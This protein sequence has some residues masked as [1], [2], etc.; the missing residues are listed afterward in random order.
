M[1][2]LHSKFVLYSLTSTTLAGFATQRAEDYQ[3]PQNSHNECLIIQS[4][5][6]A[7]CHDRDDFEILSI[8]NHEGCQDCFWFLIMFSWA[9]SPRQDRFLLLQAT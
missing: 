2:K 6:T 1:S 4:N 7:T 3:A 5:V 8:L 9:K